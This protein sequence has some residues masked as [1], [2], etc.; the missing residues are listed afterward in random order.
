MDLR[1][2]PMRVTDEQQLRTAH[3][4]MPDWEFL[5]G[6]DPEEPWD[7]FVGRRNANRLGQ[8]LQPGWVPDTFLVADIEGV[9]VGRVSIRHELSEFLR[10]YGGHIGYGVLPRFQR[11]S[12]ATEILRQALV[13]ARSLDIVRVL[14]TCD[15]DNVGSIRT[16]EKC[17][18]VFDSFAMAPN[19][20][21]RTRRYWID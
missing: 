16:I 2:R 17:G 3:K 15:D 10:N 5:L 19:D 7:V 9:I 6:Y 11:R 1:L 13:V 18:G 21:V 20:T 4:E 14:V 12:Y 8:Q